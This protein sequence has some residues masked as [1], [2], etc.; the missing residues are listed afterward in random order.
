MFYWIVMIFEDVSNPFLVTKLR[1]YH[2]G[3]ESLRF[4]MISIKRHW[5]LFFQ[6]IP[7]SFGKVRELVKEMKL[8][9]YVMQRTV[10]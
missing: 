10:A 5:M 4:A 7:I 2:F 1:G 6:R 9:K 8:P 3:P